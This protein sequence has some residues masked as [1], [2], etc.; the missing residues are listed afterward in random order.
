M[1]RKLL[2]GTALGSGLAFA[3]HAQDVKEV[4]MLHWWTS[5]GEA[6]A[7]NVLKEDLA[8][9]G[10]AW[11]DVPVAGGGGDAAMTA[12]KAMVAAGNYPTASQMLGYTVLD[13]AAAGVMGDLTETAV[14]EGWDKS[15]PAA[16][17]KFSVYDGKWVAAPVNVHS[18]NWL[19]INK[20]V[21]D[22]IGGTEP[23][24]FDDFIALL[25]KAK[26]AGVIPLALGGQNWQEATM[27][28]SVVLSTGG[29]EF[30]KKA[31]ND[32]DEESLKSD[33][34]KKS[35]D[36]LA[37]L[38]TYVD[39]NFSGRDW[40][41]A[42]AMVIKGDALVQVMG[43]WA[44]GEFNAAKKAPGTDF[45][46]Y[47][48][49]GTDGSVVYN[50]DMFGMFDVP[51]DRKA[52][53]VALATATLSKSFQSAFNVVKGSVPARTDV[54]DTDFDACGKKGMADLK[55]ANEG[56]TLFGS[57][58]QGYGAPPAV[59]NAYKDVV[60]KFVHGQIK[61]SDEAVTQ[62]VN[63]IEDAK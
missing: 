10:F 45:L 31:F 29:P 12:L 56:G 14:K 24:T 21:M 36:N 30:Y 17:Q 38:V 39:P 61:T 57:L 34:M 7:L 18:V 16:L 27:F 4:E 22:K 33:T 60:S 8:K 48:F 50:S 26:A 25:D 20:A 51:E 1:L 19:W 41:L 5:G 49:P 32:L 58:A 37:K 40:N 3:A 55:A 54:P 62:L 46:C 35:F 44:K 23:K 9:Q 63:A 53:Q 52:A 47:R 28:D 42:T 6:A 43:D 11:K 15:V 13:Y 59:A 2:I